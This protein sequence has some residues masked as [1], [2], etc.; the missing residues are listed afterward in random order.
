MDRSQPRTGRMQNPGSKSQVA[1]PSGCPH[2]L[3]TRWDTHFR[4][5][6]TASG[7]SF[8]SRLFFLPG[9]TDAT[10]REMS[11]NL[12]CGFYCDAMLVRKI[13]RLDRNSKIDGVTD[14]SL[15][16]FVV[17]LPSQCVLGAG[18]R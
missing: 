1:Y 4:D 14:E 12:R 17:L 8:A 6:K 7:M 16:P 13:C 9:T 3:V 15:D 5:P 11:K 2:S 10:S 18:M